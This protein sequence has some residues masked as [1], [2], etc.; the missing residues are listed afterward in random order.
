[1]AMTTG[2]AFITCAASAIGRSGLLPL[3]GFFLIVDLVLLG[4]NMLKIAEGGWFPLLVAPRLLR[5][6]GVDLGPRARRALRAKDALP[7]ETLHRA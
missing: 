1:M 2:L 6:D 5:D 3:F 7:L 4:A